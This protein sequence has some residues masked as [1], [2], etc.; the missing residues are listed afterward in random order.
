MEGCGQLLKEWVLDSRL[1]D[2]AIR[3]DVWHGE[4]NPWVTKAHVDFTV[5]TIFDS[6]PRRLARQRTPSV[7]QTLGRDPWSPPG[8]PPLG[9][10]AG[11]SH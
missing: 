11:S 4:Q 10:A 8:E 7:R 9:W 1:A 6:E 5:G 2:I 3:V